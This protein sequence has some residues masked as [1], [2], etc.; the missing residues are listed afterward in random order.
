MTNRA[1]TTV[2]LASLVA[3]TSTGCRRFNG[4]K[5]R[6][7]HAERY[8]RALAQTTER[9]LAERGPLGLEDCVRLALEHSLETRSAE[10][11]QRIAKLDG[12]IAFANFLPSVSVG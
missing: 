7:D 3:V 2:L 11:Q 9:A 4:E 1:I 12:K 10:I 8:P 5:V 6:R